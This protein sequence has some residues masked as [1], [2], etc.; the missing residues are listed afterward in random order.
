L[1]WAFGLERC[2][3]RVD[4][5][6][7]MEDPFSILTWVDHYPFFNFY[8]GPFFFL[9][10]YLVK[11]LLELVIYVQI[12]TFEIIIWREVFDDDIRLA[13]V[14]HALYL[15]EGVRNPEVKIVILPLNHA[16]QVIC[17]WLVKQPLRVPLHLG[18]QEVVLGW[19]LPS[20]LSMVAFLL[21]I[22]RK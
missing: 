7:H 3:W 11:L 16:V 18:T 10:H 1:G 19:A 2:S 20:I 8:R 4:A 5:L 22:K 17:T 6:V 14:A 13:D 9:Q 15:T 21:K 12:S